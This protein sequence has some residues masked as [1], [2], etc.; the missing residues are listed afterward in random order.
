[1]PETLEVMSRNGRSHRFYYNDG[2]IGNK[3]ITKVVELRTNWRYVLAAGSYV[4]PSKTALSHATGVYTVIKELPLATLHLEDLP[5]ELHPDFRKDIEDFNIIHD[6]I[7]YN[8]YGDPLKLIRKHDSKLDFLLTG[9]NM[10]YRSAS[11][12]DM[13]TCSKLWFWGY[14]IDEIA[15]IMHKFRYR[16]KFDR[17]EYLGRTIAKVITGDRVSKS[18]LYDPDEEEETK[19]LLSNVSN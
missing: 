5:K 9:S 18:L 7:W 6:D 12:A 11:E 15:S 2:N 3:D 17:S 19:S 10:Y 4:P 1:L 16:D 14:N 13:A 8:V